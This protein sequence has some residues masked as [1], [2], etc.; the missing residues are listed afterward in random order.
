LA[1]EKISFINEEI[2]RL[3]RIYRYQTKRAKRDRR[4]IKKGTNTDV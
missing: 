1:K 4:E 3:N 2:D